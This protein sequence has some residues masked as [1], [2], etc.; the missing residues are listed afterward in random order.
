MF[1]IGKLGSSDESSHKH[2]RPICA[3]CKFLASC[4][5]RMGTVLPILKQSDK[6]P[7]SIPD[8]SVSNFTFIAYDFGCFFKTCQIQ[9]KSLIMKEESKSSQDY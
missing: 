9:Q 6:F 5:N 2:N 7:F 3:T 1:K 4:Q 8:D